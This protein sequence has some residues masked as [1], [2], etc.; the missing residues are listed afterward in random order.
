M[1]SAHLSSLGLSR[2]WTYAALGVA[3]KRTD[4]GA[5]LDVD[6]L[7]TMF[8]AHLI[9]PTI[10]LASIPGCGDGATGRKGGNKV[11]EADAQRAVLHAEGVEAEPWDGAN[12]ADAGLAHPPGAGCE[13]DLLEK[14]QLA[15]ESSRFV[16]G[17]GPV[18]GAFDPS[19]VASDP[20][21]SW[22][23]KEVALCKAKNWAVIRTRIEWRAVSVVERAATCV[24]RAWAA[25][26]G[27]WKLC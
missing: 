4:Y 16:I 7:G 14:G 20:L 23:V 5:E 26:C 19:G 3:T 27:V 10:E 15:D 22:V 11:G 25:R 21:V 6:S 18:A 9:A 1:V 17:L 12:I 8:L 2:I 13:V 24:V